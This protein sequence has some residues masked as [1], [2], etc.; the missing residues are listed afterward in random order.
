MIKLDLADQGKIYQSYWRVFCLN[1]C[2]SM[3]NLCNHRS[4]NSKILTLSIALKF[5]LPLHDIKAEWEGSTW[6]FTTSSGTQTITLARMDEHRDDLDS[7]GLSNSEECAAGTNPF[8]PDT[9]G[10]GLTDFE[11]IILTE[12]SPIVWDSVLDEVSDYD[13]WYGLSTPLLLQSNTNLATHYDVDGDGIANPFDQELLAGADP[14][15]PLP[16]VYHPWLQPLPTDTD[17]DGI[18]DEIENFYGLS[19]DDAIDGLGDLDGDGVTNAEQYLSH[20]Q[21]WDR[22]VRYDRDSDGMSDVYERL[23]GFDPKNPA[24]AVEDPDGDGV[25]N[26]EEVQLGLNPFKA[27]TADIPD[28]EVLEAHLGIDLDAPEY[29][30]K[31]KG[32]WDGDGMPDAWEHRYGAWKYAAGGLNLRVVDAQADPDDDG[33]SNLGEYRL[34]TNPLYPGM[35]DGLGDGDEDADGDGVQNRF[36]GFNLSSY[37]FYL[38]DKD[39]NGDGLDDVTGTPV[40]AP[41]VSIT[42]PG[43]GSKIP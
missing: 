25:L 16:V 34:G 9:D 36:E 33:L 14:A 6:K 29:A 41:S 12:S 30:R 43:N 35:E 15:W 21:I 38:T 7:D 1:V 20:R 5:L 18:P 28:K 19:K 27:I 40:D 4:V 2:G 11:E 32:D 37:G 3:L 39:K 22:L 24:D 10:D 8:S 23:Y 42:A 31:A 17:G 26:F 13:V